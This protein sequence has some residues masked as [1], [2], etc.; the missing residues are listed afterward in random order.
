MCT[1]VRTYV[2]GLHLSVCC[3]SGAQFT[4]VCMYKATPICSSQVF[5]QARS[6]SLCVLAEEEEGGGGGPTY[7][8]QLEEGNRSLECEQKEPLDEEDMR[9][10]EIV[11]RQPLRKSDKEEAEAVE[12]E[13]TKRKV[14]SPSQVQMTSHVPPSV[15]RPV[16]LHGC[17]NCTACCSCFGAA[18]F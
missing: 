6:P 5:S 10:R 16:P 2:Y 8:A 15:A 3:L 9:G 11:Y 13:M 17:L 12:E 7:A 1:Y 4:I 14:V 18:L